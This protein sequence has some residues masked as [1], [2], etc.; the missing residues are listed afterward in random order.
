M[1]GPGPLSVISSV[2]G[3]LRSVEYTCAVSGE[4]KV[5]PVFVLVRDE[6]VLVDTSGG[7]LDQ[8]VKAGTPMN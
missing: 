2:A 7:A 1:Y 8:L 6:G 4:C 5:G 3:P